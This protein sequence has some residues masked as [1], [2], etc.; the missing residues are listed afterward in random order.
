[1]ADLK[2]MK[3]T[4]AEREARYKDAETSAIGDAP[5]YPYGLSI[6]LEDEALEKLGLSD[7]PAVGTKML[8]IAEVEVTSCSV[9]EN[10]YTKGKQ[11]RLGIQITSMCLEDAPA[12][13]KS[14]EELL[15][16]A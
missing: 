14:A 5:S 1:M 4:K 16:K 6:S 7:L 3:V 10:E 13:K 9:S 8:L 12:A 11:K 2:S 15:Y